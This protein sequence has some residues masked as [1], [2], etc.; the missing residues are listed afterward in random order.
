CDFPPVSG[1]RAVTCWL[2][3]IDDVLA[4][5][6]TADVRLPVRA[7]IDG[8]VA[9]LTAR[10]QL[11]AE[12]ARAGNARRESRMLRGAR[13]SFTRLAR[14]TRRARRNRTITRTLASTVRMRLA[15]ARME[16]RLLQ[17]DNALGVP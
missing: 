17:R 9:N 11:T 16:L 15:R 13:R 12:A 4:M 3:G 7:S 5:A 8:V 2:V 10:L 6:S 14:L 1:L